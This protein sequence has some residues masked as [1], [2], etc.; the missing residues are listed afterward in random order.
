MPTATKEFYKIGD[1]VPGSGVYLCV[2]CGYT[3]YFSAGDNFT[4]CL[5]CLAGTPDGPPGYQEP[6]NEFWQPLN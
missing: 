5:V 4:T 1:I 6:E 3:Q 2:P